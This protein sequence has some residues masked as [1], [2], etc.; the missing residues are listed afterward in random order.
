MGNLGWYQV[1]TS[2]AKKVGGPLKLGALI[3]GTGAAT[4]AVVTVGA[5][6]IKGKVSR[7]LDE[8]NKVR[9]AAVVHTV[10]REGQSN[11]GLLLK[12]GDQ[13]KVLELDGDAALIELLGDTNNPYFVSAKFLESI[14]DY[15]MTNGNHGGAKS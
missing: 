6:A 2:V 7:T 1:M 11:E 9:A 14:S 12:E 13:F 15:Q 10:N 4:G 5:G 8:K 3:F